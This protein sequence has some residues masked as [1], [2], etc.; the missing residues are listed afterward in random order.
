MLI[1]TNRRYVIPQ[2]SSLK[3]V[4]GKGK[5]NKIFRWEYE[6]SVGGIGTFCESCTENGK[7]SVALL[8]KYFLM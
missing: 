5:Y 8:K 3:I 6:E 4:D 1:A 7:E 2:G